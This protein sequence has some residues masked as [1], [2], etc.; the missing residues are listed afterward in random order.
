MNRI[1][2]V[3]VL[4]CTLSLSL[5]Q[6]CPF[7]LGASAQAE[8]NLVFC[9]QYR[10]LACCNNETE[11]ALQ[12]NLEEQVIPLYAN[13]GCYDTIK[14]FFCAWLCSPEQATF[15]EIQD[16]IN[17]TF[18]VSETLATAM[19]AVCKDVCLPFGGGIRVSTEYP[20]AFEFITEFNSDNDP[21]YVVGPTR[22][23]IFYVEGNKPNAS[24]ITTGMF[25]IYNASGTDTGAC[26]PNPTVQNSDSNLLTLSVSAILLLLLTVAMI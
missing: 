5:A 18:Y 2:L 24:S 8:S 6:T 17:V 19:Y 11:A 9:T 1:L 13:Y 20:E 21:S 22:P 14:D 26:P 16:G 4:S 12:A 23:R 10:S 25:E 15:T 3:I 7:A